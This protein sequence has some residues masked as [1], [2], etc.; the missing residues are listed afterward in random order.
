MNNGIQAGK[1]FFEEGIPGFPQLQFFQLK[2]HE[3]NSPFYSLDSMEEEQVGFWLVDPFSFFREYQFTLSD[4]A[5]A[6]LRIDE[7][8]TPVGVL[9]IVTIRSN[10]Q[11]TVNLKAPIVLNL[12]NRMGRQVILNDDRYSVRQP[13]VP[14]NQ[15]QAGG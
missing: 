6:S 14:V 10:N 11:V 8:S 15:Q 3:P 7:T 9:N 2:Q 4:S 12:A 5:K 1:L 13:L